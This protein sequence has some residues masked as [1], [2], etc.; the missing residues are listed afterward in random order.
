MQQ[1]ICCKHKIPCPTAK[2]ATI[3][4]MKSTGQIDSDSRIG[5]W[6]AERGPEAPI[7]WILIKKSNT[8]S[9]MHPQSPKGEKNNAFYGWKSSVS[10]SE[11]ETMWIYFDYEAALAGKVATFEAFAFSGLPQTDIHAGHFR[12]V[13][14]GAVRVVAVGQS[15]DLLLEEAFAAAI[16]LLEWE[17]NN[18]FRL[19]NTD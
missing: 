6:F 14:S 9:C 5:N 1:L 17:G 8:D 2:L 18:Y 11:N 3:L 4:W 13:Q 16:A 12:C 19:L 10:F 15:D 7:N